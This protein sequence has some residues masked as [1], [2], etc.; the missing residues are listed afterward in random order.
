MD[1]GKIYQKLFKAYK[2]RFS[3]EKGE[4]VQEK[5]N[6]FWKSVKSDSNVNFLVEKE[7]NKLEKEATNQSIMTFF[8]KIKNKK[9]ENAGPAATSNEDLS[10]LNIEVLDSSESDSDLMLSPT[11]FS[12]KASV[13]RPN[14]AA[15]STNTSSTSN[16]ASNSAS[17]SNSS[18]PSTSAASSPCSSPVPGRKYNTPRQDALTQ[19][20]NL[21]NVDLTAL[22]KKRNLGACDSEGA[23]QIRNLEK[24]LATAKR[25]LDHKKNDQ[26]K[27]KVRRAKQRAVLQEVSRSHKD[28]MGDLRV[29]ESGGR[30]SL[31]LDQPGI[32]KA[33]VEI[34]SSSSAAHDKRQMEILN[35]CR[36]I[37]SLQ[38][39][40]EILG[41]S[42]SRSSVYL[43]LLPRRAKTAEA[44][45]HINPAPVKILRARDDLH[46]GHADSY[47]CKATIDHL[48][49]LAAILGNDQV[50]ILSQD[51]KAKVPIGIP[52][53]SKQQAIMM[54]VE[55]RIKLPDHSFPV[56]SGYK[57][58]PS[59]Y[60]ALAVGNNLGEKTTIETAGPTYIAIRSAKYA[61]SSSQTHQSDFNRLLTLEEFKKNIRSKS[62]DYVKPVVIMLVDGGPDQNPRYKGAINSAIE[63]FKAHDLDALFIATNAPGRSA[64]NPVEHRMAPLSRAL[65]GLILPANHFK[66][67]S[68]KN[69]TEKQRQTELLNFKHAGKNSFFLVFRILAYFFNF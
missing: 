48:K 40:L 29:R 69:D 34:V 39:E 49:E 12:K 2:I 61:G 51:D 50:L 59:V 43:R 32:I 35:T 44:A 18:T 9:K 27:N 45:R 68:D 28:L 36:T 19:Q 30:P 41:Y 42:L 4:Y 13:S 38:K 53:A 8:D 64:F 33:I 14:S 11:G 60:M 67:N 23:K 63:I 37:D 1:K 54:N 16:S 21:I 25:A 3:G 31:D 20:I 52:A 66:D 17:T 62:D 6:A 26:E 46:K 47:F 15:S 22:Y 57:L 65:S 55:Y 24:Q 5:C 10:D 7:I 58:I 56:A